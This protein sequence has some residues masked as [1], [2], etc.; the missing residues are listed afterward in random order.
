ML[1]RR[2]LAALLALP[3]LPA[4]AAW[5]EKPIRLI[6]PYPPGGGTDV[7]ARLLSGPLAARFGQAVLVE[8]KAGAAGSIGAAEVARAAPD[9]TTLLIDALGHAVNPALLRGLPFDYATAFTPISQ[10]TRLPQIMIAPLS[11]PP[12]LRD[13]VAAARGKPDGFSFGS[14]GNGT[15]AHLAAVLFTRAASLQ[16]EHVPYRGGSTAMQ[17]VLAGEVAFTFATVNTAAPLIRE[18]QLRGY[19]VVGERRLPTLPNVPTLTEAG[20]PGCDL[21]E[22]N[23]LFAPAAT[24]RRIIDTL[25][26]AFSTALRD[27]VV[28]ERFAEL[29]AEP[30]GTSPTNF[31][32]FV[33]AQRRTM[34]ALV[35]EA[36]ITAG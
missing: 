14:S 11:G 25:Y 26:G 27:P 12:S 35:Q 16:M 13:F 3:A 22:W 18:G 10:L 1:R 31:A 21:F 15:G 7:T 4:R 29:G 20:Y 33:A 19:A 24:P 23:G 6:S 9:G 30:L 28:I 32:A 2:T 34:A 36:G 8:N 17:A 5:P